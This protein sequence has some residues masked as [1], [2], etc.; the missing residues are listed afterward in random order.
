M[1]KV[2][3]RLLLLCA[4]CLTVGFAAAQDSS[5]TADYNRLLEKYVTPS[6][7]KYGAW[8]GNAADLKALQGVVD[9][10]AQENVS[11]LGQKEQLAFYLNAYNAWILHE[12]LEKYP[13]KS[14]KDLLFTF[15]TSRRIKVAG[16]QT[17]F[18]DLEKKTI[19]G[20]FSN[21]NVHFALNCASRS[22]PPL[23]PQAFEGSK[24]EAQLDKLAKNFVNSEKGVQ[25]AADK[26]S[27][28]LSK[29]FDWYKDDFKVGA[30]AFINQRRSP[31]IPKD[32]KIS[33]QDYD[34]SLNEAK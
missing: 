11:S 17:S 12:A 29:I 20:K 5:W 34:W 19:R 8:K 9:A 33:Y 22:C 25:L 23:Q 13:T 14:V 26:K 4:G 1:T 3:R 31:P 2:L 18:N 15:F 27:A 16:Q 28:A 30:L 7:V 32:A 10:I 21:P 24:L 6:G